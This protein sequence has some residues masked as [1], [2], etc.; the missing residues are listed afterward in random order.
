MRLRIVNGDKRI[1]GNVFRADL[2]VNDLIDKAGICPVFQQ[3]PHQIGQEIAMRADGGIDAAP[4][5]F[6]LEN[7]VM[8]GLAHAMQALEFKGALVACHVEDGSGGMGVMGGELRIDAVRHRQ[9]L[10]RIGDIAHIRRRFGGEDRKAVDPRHLCA[11]DLGIPVG[12]LDEAHHDLAVEA[13]GKVVKEI[14]HMAGAL[15]V[16]LHHNAKA[17]PSGKRRLFQNGLDH[18]ERQR[19]AIRLF[20]VNVEAHLG[21]FRQ[22]CEAA[23]ARH[24]NRHDLLALR[25][26]IARVQ[27]RK[28]DRNA[29]VAAD[30]GV[31]AGSGD[32]GDRAAVTEMIA[33]GVPIGARGLSQHV[34]GIAVALFLHACRAVHGTLNGLAQ[35][36]LAAHLL[37]CA[38]HGGADHR[39]AQPLD[40]AAQMAHGARFFVLEHLAGQHQSPG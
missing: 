34:I 7:D 25:H 31:G 28:L 16:S 10:A 15:T 17:V 20:G 26:L 3:T 1:A 32:R 18:V 35:H 37:H 30:V 8:Q 13:G 39:L 14:N 6:C 9:E 12:A 33:G 38:A 11:L 27:R 23:Q 21:G 24:Q 19:Q 29:G 4:G 5:G 2:F 36:E 22:E 40:G